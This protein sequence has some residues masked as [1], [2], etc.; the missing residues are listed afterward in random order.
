ML[1][2]CCCCCCCCRCCCRRRCCWLLLLLYF[3]SRVCQNYPTAVGPVWSL[4]TYHAACIRELPGMIIRPTRQRPS[5]KPLSR[6]CCAIEFIFKKK[7]KFVI[8]IDTRRRRE[9]RKNPPLSHFEPLI[10]CRCQPHLC[11]NADISNVHHVPPRPFVT[12]PCCRS[13]I[14]F[15]SVVTLVAIRHAYVPWEVSTISIEAF[16]SFH[17]AY[18]IF[19]FWFNNK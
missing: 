3:H 6:L 16:L 7:M 8:A 5:V 10:S 17:S 1:L 15:L 13:F 14:P 2:C 11:G 18:S 19:I 4:R 9:T 12:Y